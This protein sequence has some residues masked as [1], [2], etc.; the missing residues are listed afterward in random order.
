[1]ILV[2]PRTSPTPVGS[3]IAMLTGLA[4]PIPARP[5]ALTPCA[6]GAKADALVLARSNG[7]GG[8][9]RGETASGIVGLP[10]DEIVWNGNR[11]TAAI[12][13]GPTAKIE[14]MSKVAAR[15]C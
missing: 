2:S 4:R 11:V 7:P 3:V 14:V 6:T 10:A 12:G 13:R 15:S 9:L 5:G 1:M 8:W